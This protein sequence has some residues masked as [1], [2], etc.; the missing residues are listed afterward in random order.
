MGLRS[1][2]RCIEARG[3]REFLVSS[4]VKEA[5]LSIQQF[6]VLTNTV[7]SRSNINEEYSKTGPERVS[8]SSDSHNH[9]LI[10]ILEYILTCLSR[11]HTLIPCSYDCS[12]S[13]ST[14]LS[15]ISH[16][17]FFIFPADLV[18]LISS[19]CKEKFSE[20]SLCQLHQFNCRFFII[21]LF[22][23]FYDFQLHLPAL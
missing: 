3:R 11:V 13:A 4:Y 8:V 16:F 12:L 23:S 14:L 1:R 6:I 21:T 17:P 5:S 15:D 20:L 10:A 2:Q 7:S 9:Y 22:L 18:F 19:Y